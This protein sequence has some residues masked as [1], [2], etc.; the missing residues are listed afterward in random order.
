[1]AVVPPTP[2]RAVTVTTSLDGAQ[3][4][5][6]ND[7][8]SAAQAV[9][10]GEP[11]AEDARLAVDG[12]AHPGVQ[13]SHLL[14]DGAPD[15]VSTGA[16]GAS[17]PLGYAQV[18]RAAGDDGSDEVTVELLV[19][20]DARRTG[21][22]TA[23]ARAVAD[24]VQRPGAGPGGGAVAAGRTGRHGSLT[25]WSHGDHPGA[26]ALA[27]HHDLVRQ[28]ELWRME[29]DLDGDDDLP[30]LV[31]PDGVA[32]RAFE[33][34]R[35]EAGWLALNAAAFADHP[36]QGAW[37]PADLAA[38]TSAPWFDPGDLL[39][40]V[41]ADDPGRLLASHWTRVDGGTGGAGATGE[42]YVVAVSPAE[43]GRGLGGAVV[44]A[45]LHHLARRG[46]A[47]VDLY[48][49]GSDARARHVYERLGFARASTD[50]AWGRRW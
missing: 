3:R 15:P 5:A 41:D 1:M 14:A 16:P 24:V 32:L 50:V 43:Q 27:H 29:R 47:R 8:A 36:E 33:P 25:A 7:L 26:A 28:R 12:V 23:L 11:L 42:V 13:V 10:G 39:L 2:H 21:V 35:D 34:D 38:R 46:L 9:D 19:A 49:D 4:A 30:P 44:L 22:G 48:V 17:T 37:G 6:V 31:L 45:G 20:P 40:L 18:R